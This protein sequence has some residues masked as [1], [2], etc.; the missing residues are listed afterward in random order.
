MV[1]F[2][3][4]FLSYLLYPESQAP[5]DPLTN[6]PVPRAKERVEF[7]IET[8]R[9][10]K[11]KIIV[12][13]P[14]L[15]EILVVVPKAQE[16]FEILCS[17]RW[18]E[19]CPFDQKAAIECA[20]F[21][22]AALKN[23][24]KKGPASTWGKAKFDMQIVAIAIV[25]GAEAIYTDDGDISRRLKDSRIRV[26]GIADLPLPPPKQMPLNLSEDDEEQETE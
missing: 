13:T 14:A 24:E 23:E 17:S 11:Q 26:I 21:I 9:R 18:F 5:L 22:R 8:L 15:A 25:V 19:I 20:E 7:L 1:V 12:P 3:A 2:D 4:T 6:Q 16:V 10:S